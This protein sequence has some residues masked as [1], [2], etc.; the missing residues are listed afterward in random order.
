MI[1]FYNQ[2]GKIIGTI[3]GRIHGEDHLKM[4]IGN[5]DET[6]RLVVNWIKTSEGFKPDHPQETIISGLE[7]GSIQISDY[8]IEDN[9]LKKRYN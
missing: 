6:R 1:L 9:R 7:D 4:W 3:N 8:M 2:T 5:K